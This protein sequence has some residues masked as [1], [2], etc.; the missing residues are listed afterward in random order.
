MRSQRDHA[1]PFRRDESRC[2]HLVP[3][4]TGMTDDARRAPEPVQGA[5]RQRTNQRSATLVTVANDT[6]ECIEIVAVQHGP[7]CI[8]LEDEM[9]IAVIDDVKHIESSTDAAQQSRVVP[10]SPE[11]PIAIEGDASVG[12][13]PGEAAR[14]PG[15]DRLDRDGVVMV[16]ADLV[17]DHLRDQ[18]HAAPSLFRHIGANGN[19]GDVG[20]ALRFGAGVC[21]PHSIALHRHFVIRRQRTM[22]EARL[23]VPAADPGALVIERNKSSRTAV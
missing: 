21:T 22:A 2:D 13:E 23:A 19:A 11:D 8:D 15:D 3:H 16:G 4:G 9:R 14:H 6:P 5:A 10:E 18:V 1:E 20:P 7:V 17:D 12:C